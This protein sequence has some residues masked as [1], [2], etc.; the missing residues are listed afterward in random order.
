MMRRVWAAALALLLVL[1]GCAGNGGE[2]AAKG[3]PWEELTVT[4]TLELDYAKQFSVSYYTEGY[5][6]IDIEQTGEFL[7]IPEG[8]EVPAG[9]P[10]N[11]VPLRQPLDQI[12][13][14]ST[15][16]MDFF[17]TLEGL[18][19]VAFSGTDAK[20]WYIPEAREAMEDGSI[21]YAGKYRAPDYESL[22]SGGC[23]L[24][25]ENTMI[26]HIP[27]VKEK[28]EALGIP[29][30]IERSSYE[31]EPLGRMEWVKFYGVLLNKEEEAKAAFDRCLAQLE[32]LS[33]TEQTGKRAAFFYITSNGAANVR[34]SSDYVPRMMEMAGGSYVFDQMGN[35]TAL[36]TMSMD[37]ESFYAGAKDA[38]ILLYNGNLD[39]GVKTIAELLDKAPVL[40]D[41]KAVQEGKVWCTEKSLFQETMCL[42]D[43]ILDMHRIFAEED[44]SDEE[45]TYFSRLS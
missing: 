2:E 26:L 14:V 7:V 15:S 41:F 36:S 30:I 23:D 34:K 11:I 19:Q 8:K 12:Y 4:D 27:E 9:L 5:R 16:V 42:G 17:R 33:D 10:E 6:K 40:A 28:L 32:G 44:P 20:G 22:L 1:T 31:A 45:L 25:I 35:D 3:T 38:D 43:M 29:V 18:P 39:G 24:A 37:M 13:L 21:R